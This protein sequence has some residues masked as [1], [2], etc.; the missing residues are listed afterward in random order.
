MHKSTY[1]QDIYTAFQSFNPEHDSWSICTAAGGSIGLTNIHFSRL[2][3]STDSVDLAKNTLAAWLEEVDY[4]ETK[5]VT[6]TFAK[7]SF[8]LIHLLALFDKHHPSKKLAD[9]NQF[10]LERLCALTIFYTIVYSDEQNKGEL[11]KLENPRS[12]GSLTAT[13]TIFRFLYRLYHDGLVSDGPNYLVTSPRIAQLLAADFDTLDVDF[14][15]WEKGGSYGPIPF[16]VANLLLADAINLL[17]SKT[18]K[19]LSIFFD[20]T[21]SSGRFDLLSSMWVTGDTRI[22]KYR[23]TSKLDFITRSFGNDSDKTRDCKDLILLPLHRELENLNGSNFSFPWPRYTDFVNDYN[24]VASACYIV[25][26]SIMGKRGP[27]E[28]LTLRANDINIPSG[29]AQSATVNAAN[30]KTNNGIRR[31]QGVTDFV[32]LAYQTLLDL[33]YVTKRNSDLPLFSTLPF[34]H[35]PEAPPEK[36]SIQHSIFLL[37]RYYAKFI[38]RTSSK[39]E[40]DIHTLHPSIST[41]QFRHTFAEFALRRFDGNIEE[42]IRQAFQHG[43]NYTWVKRYTADKLDE[44]VNNNLNKSYIRELIPRVLRD[45]DLLDPD[46]V[47]G[48][49]IFI[50]KAVQS[51][52]QY[53]SPAELEAYLD[54]LTDEFISVTPHEYGW[55]LLYRDFSCQAKCSEDGVNPSPRSTC[56]SK[57]N[58]CVN[59][60][61]SK[62][63]H[64]ETQRMIMLTHIDFIECEAWSRHSLKQASVN[65]VRDA[66][67]LFPEFREFGEY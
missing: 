54:S 36:I 2:P 8:R 60:L 45:T 5:P 3:L 23:Q 17:S 1:E 55:C 38:E 40:L 57:C 50:K 42:L 63:S 14:H 10:D 48:M 62:S 20:L 9:L 35:A 4:S 41:H 24:T 56:S 28:V 31:A 13:I 53:M 33:G 19:Q 32:E 18:A 11:V 64:R 25:F 22:K 65:A 46:F 6:Q 43:Y 58:G 34:L 12:R 26:L 21:K 29:A 52:V 59:F 39:V 49:A 15:L 44:D 37:Q 27:S 47:G 16:V 67:N 30:H 66:Q 61:S 51:K 7:L